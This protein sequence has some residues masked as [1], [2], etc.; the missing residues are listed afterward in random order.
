M[1]N[2]SK[3]LP[4][5]LAIAFIAGATAFSG[6]ANAA[7]HGGGQGMMQRFAMLDGNGDQKITPDEMM[8]WRGAVFASMDADDDNELTMEEYM[9]VRMGSGEG[10]NPARQKMKQDEKR[11][12]FKPMDKDGSSKVSE[13]EWTAAG[14]AEITAVDTDGDGSIS[15][16]EFRNHNKSN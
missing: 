11:A 4:M 2:Y 6:L 13:A 14:K 1:T 10:K 3:T 16:M 7:S 9:T 15:L 5:T 12:R 8:E